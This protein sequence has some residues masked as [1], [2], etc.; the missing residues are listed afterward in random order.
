MVQCVSFTVPDTMEMAQKELMD[1]L[2]QKF[3]IPSSQIRLLNS[4]GHGRTS[5]AVISPVPQSVTV[6]PI[7]V[8]EFGEV[9]KAHLT[10]RQGRVTRIVAVKT[11]RGK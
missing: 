3:H 4:I 11:L 8:G 9:Y 1:I 7:P 6:Y 10:R 5:E 2:P